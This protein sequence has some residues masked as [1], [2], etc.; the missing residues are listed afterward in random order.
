MNYKLFNVLLFA[1]G[2]AIGSAV[3]W[4]VL[5]TKYEK[6]VQEEIE[7]V[8]TAFAEGMV[9]FHAAAKEDEDPDNSEEERSGVISG[10]IDW[11]E[12]EDL[13]ELDA[14][15]EA[16]YQSDMATMAEY[17]RLTDHYKTKKG[18]VKSMDKS[19]AKEPYVISPFDF[20]EIDDYDRVSLTYYA[21]NILED[22]N[23]DI[24]TEKDRDDYI[25]NK[26]LFTF[27]EYEDDSVFVRN[28]RL[29]TDFEILRDYRTY[30]QARG[31]APNQ[32]DNE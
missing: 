2:A 17:E 20:G 16:E 8:K 1:A 29:R 25:G 13:D 4:K 26:A 18:G 5:K 14:N 31:T 6:L 27:G 30:E 24:I 3:T 32:V 9:D 7:S 10:Q 21:D 19:V 12:L 15:E 22:E 23:Y 28:E 11:D